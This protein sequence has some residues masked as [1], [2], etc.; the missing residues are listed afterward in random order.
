M[1]YNFK[2]VFDVFEL[3]SSLLKLLGYRDNFEYIGFNLFQ[4]KSFLITLRLSD[5]KVL[6]WKKK[7]PEV[8]YKYMFSKIWQNLQE[9]TCVGASFL[10]NLQ[11]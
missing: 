5:G 9:N 1:Q 6:Q 3:F 10:I 8:F 4:T 2:Y 7:P 11:A